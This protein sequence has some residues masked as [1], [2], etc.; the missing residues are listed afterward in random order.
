MNSNIFVSGL[1]RDGAGQF[2][3][4]CADLPATAV[5]KLMMSG[6]FDGSTGGSTGS[7]GGSGYDADPARGGHGNYEVDYLTPTSKCSGAV[8]SPF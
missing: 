4:A 6:C 1:T 5:V 7:A 2:V 8:L 3:T